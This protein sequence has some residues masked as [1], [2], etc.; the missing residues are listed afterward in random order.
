MLNAYSVAVAF[1]ENASDEEAMES[2][3]FASAAAIVGVKLTFKDD[4]DVTLP[5]VGLVV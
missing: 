4:V 1:L 3:V 5:T 2:V